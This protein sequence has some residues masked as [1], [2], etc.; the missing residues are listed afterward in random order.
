MGVASLLGL[1]EGKVRDQRRA[2]SGDGISFVVASPLSGPTRQP[3][4]TQPTG[5]GQFAITCSIQPPELMANTRWLLQRAYNR[6]SVRIDHCRCRLSGHLY[7]CCRR[8]AV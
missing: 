4:S 2:R 3:P 1:A 8:H 7:L 6:V 5:A